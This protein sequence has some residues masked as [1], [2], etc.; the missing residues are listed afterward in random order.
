MSLTHEGAVWCECRPL[1]KLR[2]VETSLSAKEIL[3]SKAMDQTAKPLS[4]S[5]SEK[6]FALPTKF[7]AIDPTGMPCLRLA[8]A[9]SMA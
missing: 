4:V 6:Q 8:A 9:L 1:G 7:T 5:L 3:R 2:T